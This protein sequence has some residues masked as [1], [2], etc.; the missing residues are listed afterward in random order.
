MLAKCFAFSSPCQEFSIPPSKRPLQLSCSLRELRLHSTRPVVAPL[1]TV[2]SWEPSAC[3]HRVSLEFYFSALRCWSKTSLSREPRRQL[4]RQSPLPNPRQ[5]PG[6]PLTRRY[7]PPCRA[8]TPFSSSRTPTSP[9][10]P[11]AS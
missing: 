10:D 11:C 7:P 2:F 6:P 4:P 3:A 8:P 5:R 9:A 1:D